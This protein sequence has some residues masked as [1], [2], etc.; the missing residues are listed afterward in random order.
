MVLTGPPPLCELY[1]TLQ[2]TVLEASP[3]GDVV[4]ASSFLL[5]LRVTAEQ[6]HVHVGQGQLRHDPAWG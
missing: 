1:C 2:A 3:G 5:L 6:Q 4:A